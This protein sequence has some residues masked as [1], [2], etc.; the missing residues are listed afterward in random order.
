MPLDGSAAWASRETAE[1]VEPDQNLS[2][3]SV[4]GMSFKP[5]QTWLISKVV[6]RYREALC[7]RSV[8]SRPAL[9]RARWWTRAFA[10]ESRVWPR[11]IVF[12]L[13]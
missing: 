1:I 3:W 4:S 10:P 9:R 8:S 13:N 2:G 11:I 6:H 5:R 7:L 12:L